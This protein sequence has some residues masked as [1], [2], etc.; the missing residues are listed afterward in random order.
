MKVKILWW[1]SPDGSQ[2]EVV[3]AYDEAIE[4]AEQDFQLVKDDKSRIWSLTVIDYVERPAVIPDPMPLSDAERERF[5]Y[6]LNLNDD[7]IF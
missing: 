5:T 6:P 4:R 3:R 7:N 1:K 2:V